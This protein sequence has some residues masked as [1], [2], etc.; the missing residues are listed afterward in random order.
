M[1]GNPTKSKGVN[2]IIE[3][4]V[5]HEVTHHGFSSEAR[6]TFEYIAF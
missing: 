1:K 3:I 5:K 4:A 6:R 2:E